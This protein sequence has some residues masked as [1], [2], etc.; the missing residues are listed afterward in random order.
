MQQMNIA[1]DALVAEVE[2]QK[3]DQTAEI[4]SEL[5]KEYEQQVKYLESQVKTL[6]SQLE[7]SKLQQSRS[8]VEVQL[9]K[10]LAETQSE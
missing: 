6:T 10:D 3:S 8:Q 9:V 7:D 1:H 2:R 4:V 5:K